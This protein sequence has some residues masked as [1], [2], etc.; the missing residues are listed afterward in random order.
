M[1]R[2]TGEYRLV[3]PVDYFIPN[4]LP[5]RD[6]DFFLDAHMIQLVSEITFMCGQ[7]NE[8]ARKLP[9]LE[10]FVRAYVIKEALLSSDI[11]GIHTTMLEV[12]TQPLGEQKTTKE[13]QLVLNYYNALSDGL[14]LM[15]SDPVSSR[16]LL[17]VHQ[18]LLNGEG[19]HVQPGLYRTQNVRVGYLVP[20]MFG[21]VPR[22]MHELET[23]IHDRDDQ[24]MLPAIVRAGLVHVQF[25]TIHPFIDGNGRVGRMLIQLMLIESGLLSVPIVYPSYYF[26]KQRAEYYFRLDQVRLE[27]DFEGWILFY[28][29]ALKES[30]TDAYRRAY[31]IEELEKRF[32]QMITESQDFSKTRQ[33]ALRALVI[34]FR[35]PVITVSALS[36]ALDNAYNTAHALIDRFIENG[37]LVETT[38]RGK[39]NKMYIM[40]E[41]LDLLEKKY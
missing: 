1:V 9:D 36:V 34:C 28:L 18:D 31:D 32:T 30:C 2:R 8:L 16:V 38:V 5:P 11:E 26:K 12:F 6:P 20:P 19:A 40:K 10:R 3:G 37:I 33:N 23:Y 25:E 35:Q 39:N 41:Y 29:K 15:D 13:T 4:A 17:K 27:G 22:L 21:E 7:L 14:K 24:N